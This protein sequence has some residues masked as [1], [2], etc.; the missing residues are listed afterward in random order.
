MAEPL[1]AEYTR[2]AAQLAEREMKKQVPR[3]SHPCVIL[4][5]HATV[6][7]LQ[8]RVA[9]LE[10]IHEDSMERIAELTVIAEEAK[11]GSTTEV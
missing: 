8:A 10:R 9:E 3:M 4:R 11:H 7:Q 5:W 2:I 6:Q 1:T